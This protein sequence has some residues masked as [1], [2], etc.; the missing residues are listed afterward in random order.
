MAKAQQGQQMQQMQMQM[1]QAQ[2]QVEQAKAQVEQQK[3]QLD[4]YKADQETALKQWT[5]RLHAE[6][7]EAK[8]IGT[9]TADLQRTELEGQYSLA[10]GAAGQDAGGG[11]AGERSA[12]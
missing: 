9:A 2:L 1:A 7:E 8:L 4:K 3:V 11:E 10:Q 6:I 12:A 5:E